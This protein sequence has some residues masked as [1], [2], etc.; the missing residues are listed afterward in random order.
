[1][2][3]DF[4]GQV[5]G[6]PIELWIAAKTSEAVADLVQRR[7]AGEFPLH[8]PPPEPCPKCGSLALYS[9]QSPEPVDYVCICPD[10]AL[11][12]TVWR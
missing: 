8:P 6:I 7:E 9:E 3:D 10:D 5:V 1:M 12:G 11:I 2:I 4:W